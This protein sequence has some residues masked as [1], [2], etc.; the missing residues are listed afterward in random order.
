MARIQGVG[1]PPDSQGYEQAGR[2]RSKAET[3]PGQASPIDVPLFSC[4]DL[5]CMYRFRS[6]VMHLRRSVYDYLSS[7]LR[8]QHAGM[9]VQSNG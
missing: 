3:R 2:H 6:A 7:S 8:M 5:L 4:L 1:A 9:I